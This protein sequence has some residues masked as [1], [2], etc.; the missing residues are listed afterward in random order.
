MVLM[1]TNSATIASTGVTSGSMMRKNTCAWVAPS[2]WADSSNSLGTVSKKPFI[3]Q[4]LMLSA[5]P[6]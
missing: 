3:N 5:P 4:V 1:N 6:R 2:I